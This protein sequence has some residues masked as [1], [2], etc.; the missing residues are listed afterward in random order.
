MVSAVA[1]TRATSTCGAGNRRSRN[2]IRKSRANPSTMAVGM[3]HAGHRR[4][5]RSIGRGRVSVSRDSFISGGSRETIIPCGDEKGAIRARSG[6]D[7]ASRFTVSKLQDM[8]VFPK[9]WDRGSVTHRPVW[10]PQAGGVS[11][12]PV[13]IL[14]ARSPESWERQAAAVVIGRPVELRASSSMEPDP[15]SGGH[16]HCSNPK[17]RSLPATSRPNKDAHCLQ[18]PGMKA[19]RRERSRWHIPA[20]LKHPSH[21][22]PQPSSSGIACHG[23]NLATLRGLRSPF[24]LV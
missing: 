3:S 1:R 5:P 13:A 15:H 20:S 10:L 7:Y 8:L 9:R 22:N 21:P 6:Q 16:S 19:R 24:S 11:E 2:N 12:W 18:W 14:P 17:C 23:T 4:G